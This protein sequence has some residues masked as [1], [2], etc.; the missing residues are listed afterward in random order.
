MRPVVIE[1]NLTPMVE[2]N[3]DIEGT[4]QQ[5]LEISRRQTNFTQVAVKADRTDFGPVFV[6]NN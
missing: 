3:N 2:R 6:V 4:F 5:P 1:N